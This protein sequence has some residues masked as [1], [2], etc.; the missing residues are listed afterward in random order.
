MSPFLSGYVNLMKSILGIGIISYPRLF[1][2]NGIISTL[3]LML[4]CAILSTVS[5]FIYLNLNNKQQKTFS[6]FY[7]NK[8][9]QF[10]CTGIIVCKAVSV[11]VS[12]I[13]LIRSILSNIFREYF[14]LQSVDKVI[15]PVFLLVNLPLATFR[16][17]HKLRITSFIGIIAVCIMVILTF[18]RII[19]LSRHKSE[20]RV[21]KCPLVSSLGSFIYSFTCHQNI[22]TF[23]NES[24]LPLP[25]CYKLIVCVNASVAF[26]FILFGLG[27]AYFTTISLDFFS[28]FPVDR[29]SLSRIT[30]SLN[31]ILSVISQICFLLTTVFSIPLQLNAG[32]NYL[33]LHKSVH[34][35]LF[36]ALIFLLGYILSGSSSFL[37]IIKFVG[38]TVNA[39]LCYVAAGLFYIGVR[40]TGC[41]F[42]WALLLV[43]IGSGVFLWTVV[44]AIV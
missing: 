35:Y 32:C 5:L 28:S 8:Q 31:N 14:Q 9:I 24:R 21:F 33:L 44:N 30:F 27:N 42:V 4:I 16:K 34:R 13:I 6:T 23:Q 25:A 36:C 18:I 37:Q 43:A 20:L 22:F 26:L 3:I 40:R 17:F 11:T 15:F 38:G 19:F 39:V 2:E 1:T 29:N 10:L 7:D 12:Y 41:F